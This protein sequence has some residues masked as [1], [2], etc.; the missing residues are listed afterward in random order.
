MNATT[1]DEARK[2]IAKAILSAYKEVKEIYLANLGKLEGSLLISLGNAH[3]RVD[4][5]SMRQLRKVLK[6]AR[7]R[8][9]GFEVVEEI[10]LA[11]KR[12]EGIPGI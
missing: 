10:D 6:A 3:K 5:L 8:L 1:I 9:A 4:S 7:S 2:V 11:L 12:I